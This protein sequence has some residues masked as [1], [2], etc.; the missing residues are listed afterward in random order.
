VRCVRYRLSRHTT[1]HVRISAT[2]ADIRHT[3]GYIPESKLVSG[4]ASKTCDQPSLRSQIKR[5]DTRSPSLTMPTQSI[6]PSD[7]IS[8]YY[9]PAPSTRHINHLGK[10]VRNV[11]LVPDNEPD[12]KHWLLS[13]LMSVFDEVDAAWDNAVFQISDKLEG[14]L[15]DI[16]VRQGVR[17]EDTQVHS[18]VHAVLARGK[19]VRAEL[20]AAKAKRKSREE[21][22]SGVDVKRSRAEKAEVSDR[23][24]FAFF[25]S[26][27]HTHTP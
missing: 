3:G 22:T 24:S 14:N 20:Q 13:P 4:G 12:L 2:S 10:T 6:H 17:F 7:S 9:I 11:Q 15:R 27:I 16:R 5:L 21:A 23:G 18:A 25:P 8:S 19:T 1:Q 26:H